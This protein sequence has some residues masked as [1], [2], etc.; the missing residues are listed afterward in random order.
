M[1]ADWGFIWL[2]YGVVWGGIILYGLSVF[3]RL[4][5]HGHRDRSRGKN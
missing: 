5:R 4:Y 1:P 2:G 3:W